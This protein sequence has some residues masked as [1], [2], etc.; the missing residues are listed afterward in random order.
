MSPRCS[1]DKA[2][3]EATAEAK[4]SY[5]TWSIRKRACLWGGEH[6][7]LGAVNPDGDLRAGGAQFLKE[8]SVS[9]DPQILLRDLHLRRESNDPVDSHLYE[10]QD[11]TRDAIFYTHN[12]QVPRAGRR[13]QTE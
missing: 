5:L 4:E 2:K 6:V 9:P 10:S 12:T 13:V 3:P 8:S 7:R 1:R 11:Q